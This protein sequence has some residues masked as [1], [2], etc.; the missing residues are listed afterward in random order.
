MTAVP[1]YQGMFLR[2]LG[3]NSAALGVNQGDAIRNIIAVWGYVH[4]SVGSAG[5]AGAIGAARWQSTDTDAAVTSGSPTYYSGGLYFD[6]SLMV[7]TDVENR[8]V[9]VAVRFLI[10]ALK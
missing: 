2:G 8:P 7:P 3:G 9:N 6:A 5:G 10:R 1:N 4:G